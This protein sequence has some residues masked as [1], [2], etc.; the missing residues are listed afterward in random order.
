M[1]S[2][3]KDRWIAALRSGEYEQTKGAL[4][5]TRSDAGMPPGFCCLGVLCDLAR[6]E[7]VIEP[8]GTDPYGVVEYPHGDNGDTETGALP[9]S[10]Y[11]WA[12][13]PTDSPR[14]IGGLSLATLNDRG[15]TFDAI[16]DIIEE[17]L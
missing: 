5:R 1:N 2:D 8:E 10:V 15:Y 9:R 7:G 17:R 6:Q 13:L 4:Q 3:I 14:V 12:G 11:L 16:A